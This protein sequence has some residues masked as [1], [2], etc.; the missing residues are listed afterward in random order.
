MKRAALYVRVSTSK[1]DAKGDPVQNYRLQWNALRR[2]GV[3]RGWK[4]YRVYHDRG[5]GAN[6]DRAG[7][8]ELRADARRGCFDVVAVWRFDRLARSTK[9]LIG[10]LDEFRGLGIDFV[11]LQESIDTSTPTGNLMFAIIAAFAEFERNIIQERVRAGISHARDH[12][13]R[14]GNAIGRPKAVFPREKAARLRREGYSIREIAD[15]FDVGVGTVQR[16][17]QELVEQGVRVTP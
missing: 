7:Y 10:A 15:K 13:T 11:S 3:A 6:A 5:S 4:L 9:E 8:R 12:G 14:S 17:L 2:L 16:A 1:R